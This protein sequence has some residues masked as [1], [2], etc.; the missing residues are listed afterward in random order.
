L[1]YAN[2]TFV[3]GVNN[4]FAYK[5]FNFSFQ[6]DGRVGGVISNYIQRQTFRGGRHIETVQGALGEAR[7]QDV[8]GV[9]AYV[10]E[11]VKIANSGQ[12]NFDPDGNVTNFSE[13]Q[14]APNDT[15]TF[16]QD[17]I[18]RRYGPN[19]GNLMSRSFAKLRE[20]VIGYTLPPALLG[21]VGVRQA[22]IS[23][24]GRNL[25]YFAEKKD[26]DLEQY[27]SG[28]SSGLETPTTR[29]YGINLNLTF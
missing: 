23:V 9:K 20:V 29:R 12:L 6:F 11:G 3:W 24:V 10:G 1:G 26:I 18:S 4:R 16:A 19:G 14:F 17:Y 28:G 5:N 21:R 8:L 25:L 7:K 2:P 13:L 15:K 27:I 22:T